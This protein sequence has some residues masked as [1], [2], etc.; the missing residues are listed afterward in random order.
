MTAAAIPCQVMGAGG[1]EGAPGARA[2][3][4]RRAGPATH[5][6]RRTGSPLALT[7]DRARGA[8]PARPTCCSSV[9]W[10]KSWWVLYSVRK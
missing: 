8:S 1:W 3:S 4:S 5:A 7:G 6:A 10:L 2:P 9:S